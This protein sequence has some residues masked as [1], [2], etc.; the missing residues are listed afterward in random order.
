MPHNPV[1]DSPMS[2]VSISPSLPSPIPAL[3][4]LSPE[5]SA[6]LLARAKD[7]I[8]GRIHPDP[9]SDWPGADARLQADFGDKIPPPTAEA[10][11]AIKE[12]WSLEYNYRGKPVICYRMDNGV[13]AVLGEGDEEILSILTGL[14]DNERH[15]TIVLDTHPF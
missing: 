10:V 4:G 2:N 11:R 6:A 12:D 7:I 1:L 13:L 8:A 5:R 9:L 14:S 15:D 3:S